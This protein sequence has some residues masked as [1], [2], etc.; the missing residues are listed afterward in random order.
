MSGP[1]SLTT[2]LSP[3]HAD[4]A[5]SGATITCLLTA[6]T[7]AVQVLGYL[8]GDEAP[9]TVDATL[10]VRPTDFVPRLR[11]WSPHPDCECAGA[12]RRGV[13]VDR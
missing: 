7:A 2:P 13:G 1:V 10:E 11:R 4:P 6:L 8:D 12:A 5:P 3:V 9:A